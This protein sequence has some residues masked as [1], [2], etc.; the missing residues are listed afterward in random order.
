MEA[1]HGFVQTVQGAVLDHDIRVAH[2]LMISLQKLTDDGNCRRLEPHA[3]G[4]QGLEKRGRREGMPSRNRTQ[5]G[6][7]GLVYHPHAVVCRGTYPCLPGLL[8]A[9]DGTVHL[10]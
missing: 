1:L 8:A 6:R 2:L 7:C 3:A 10:A 9:G 5:H 4:G